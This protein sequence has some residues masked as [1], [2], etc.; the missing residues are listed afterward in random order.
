MNTPNFKTTSLR[1]VLVPLSLFGAI[2]ILGACGQKTDAPTDTNSAQ[3]PSTSA[4][5]TS[6]DDKAAAKPGEKPADKASAQRAA[7]TITTASAK[8]GTVNSNVIYNGNVAA[9][10]EASVAAEVGGLRVS[11]V[12]ANIGDSVTKGQLLVRLNDASVQSE[13]AAQRAAVADA[14]AQL[15]DARANADRARQLDK[16]GAI[17][18]SQIEQYFTAEKTAK[19]RLDAAAARAQSDQ[20]RLNNARIVAPDS[21]VVSVKTA[22]VGS[23]LQPGQE[24]FRII[25]NGRL[26]FRAD[27]PSSELG[28]IKLKQVV[29][30]E[31]GDNLKTTGT[32]RAIAPTV[33][34]QTR[35]AIVYID[36]ASGS[37]IKA[38]MF[39]K[40]QFDLGQSNAVLVP[41]SAIIRR[42][43]LEY[44]FLLE[45]N[46]K[47]KQ[48]K[49]QTGSRLDDQIE[50]RGVTVGAKV[51][52]TG[53]GFLAD[54]D[55]VKVVT[56]PAPAAAK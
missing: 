33:D 13:L 15:A 39:A 28:R 20:L 44:I 7:L 36:L 22:T 51:A 38:G 55:T 3:K 8:Q 53:V 40:G 54:G 26:E 46:D 1:D 2:I 11:Q 45:N 5:K 16:T 30:V 47:V 14:Q 42:D 27:V 37:A 35:N 9:W 31:A 32:V 29:A 17:S 48:V 50:V 12:F 43:G 4:A 18:A 23:V 19:A 34:P 25:K 56:A 24:L 10:Q 41:N 21:G 52:T 6:A 49:V